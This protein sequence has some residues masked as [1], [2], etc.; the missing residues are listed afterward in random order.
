MAGGGGP[1]VPGQLLHEAEF[2]AGE[3]LGGRFAEVTERLQR[4][5]VAGSGGRVV[6]GQPL[7]HA[8]LIENPGLAVAVALV[9][10]HRLGLLEGGGGGRVVAGLPLHDT[11]L[12]RATLWPYRSPRSRNISSAC[13]WLAT[14]AR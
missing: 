8:E 11:Q 3:A 10:V 6:A 1:V 9:P 2:V 4:L 13:W 7:Q 12:H 14:A 5:L